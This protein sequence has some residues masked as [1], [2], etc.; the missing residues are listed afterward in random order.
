[1]GLLQQLAFGSAR[2]SNDTDV[3]VATQMGSLEGHLGNATKEH[4]KNSTFHLLIAF[5]VKTHR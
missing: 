5:I 3:D 4:Q 1:M 2:I